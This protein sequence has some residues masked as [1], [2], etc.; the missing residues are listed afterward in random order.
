ML[1]TLRKYLKIFNLFIPIFIDLHITWN[2]YMIRFQNQNLSNKIKDKMQ[3]NVKY[4]LLKIHE[5]Q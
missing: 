4:I 5:R 3:K 2:K 1:Q